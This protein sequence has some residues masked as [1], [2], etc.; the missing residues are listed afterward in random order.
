MNEDSEKV[1]IPSQEFKV[2]FQIKIKKTKYLF[3]NR[4]FQRKKIHFKLEFLEIQKL[5]FELEM[6]KMF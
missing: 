3:Q 6:K 1:Y 2:N 5:S 4:K